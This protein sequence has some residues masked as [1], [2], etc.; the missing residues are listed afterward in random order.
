M[1]IKRVLWAQRFNSQV[2]KMFNERKNFEINKNNNLKSN[3]TVKSIIEN[4][5]ELK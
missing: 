3:Y 2:I 1:P 5:T 4:K